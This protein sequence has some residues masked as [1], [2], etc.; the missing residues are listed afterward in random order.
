MNGKKDVMDKREKITSLVLLI[1]SLLAILIW[2]LVY[3]L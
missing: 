1:G 3:S 2:T